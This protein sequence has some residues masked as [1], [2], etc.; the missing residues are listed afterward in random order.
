[1]DEAR[2]HPR[3]TALLR[4][5]GWEGL[6]QAQ[7]RSL[8]PLLEGRHA[9]VVAPTGHGKTEAALLPV[10][11]RMLTERDALAVRKAPWPKGFKVLYVTPLRALNRDLL[12][13]LLSWGKELG[14]GI[15][16]RHGDTTPSERTKQAKDPPDLLIT[17]PE[18]LQLLLYGDTLRRH[19][20]TVRF[21]V[22]DEVH[23]LVSSERGAQL[24]VALERVEEVV[25]QPVD[26]R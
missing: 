7:Q 25:G 3:L 17:T 26:M 12:R 13:R 24:L 16:V 23:D 5:Q 10:L 20:A 18:T 6:T 2:L 19:L 21:A 9:L 11:S 15:G 1:M 8:G 4:S 22:L 14:F